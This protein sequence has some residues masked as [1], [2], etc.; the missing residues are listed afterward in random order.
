MAQRAVNLKRDS[1]ELF[2]NLESF[3]MEIECTKEYTSR[4]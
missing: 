3:Q 4:F 2:I 1:I